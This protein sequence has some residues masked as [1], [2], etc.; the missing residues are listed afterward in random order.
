M[1]KVDAF[2]DAEALVSYELRTQIPA[3]VYSS[4]PR[5]TTL[6]LPLLIIK[7]I[8]GTPPVRERLDRASIQVDSWG[9][10]KSEA[11]DL[12]DAARVKL[13]AMEGK[14]MTTGAGYPVNGVITGVTDV[15]GLVW[16]PDPPTDHDRYIF[17]V[18]VYLH[19]V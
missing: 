16:V 5:T 17:S 4:L 10:T 12:A 18:N 11:R 15:L 1:A 14:V 2:P 19:A 3:N 8:G 9:T 6:P 7:R 13:H